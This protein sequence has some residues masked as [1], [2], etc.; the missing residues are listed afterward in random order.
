MQKQSEIPQIAFAGESTSAYIRYERVEKL[1]CLI[2]GDKISQET[3]AKSRSRKRLNLE[4][5]SNAECKKEFR[6]T[7]SET[8]LYDYVIVISVL[9]IFSLNIMF[10][11]VYVLQQHPA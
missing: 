2:T 3:K 8:Q 1:R 10:C 11:I 4:D 9:L 7:L 6:F 5:L